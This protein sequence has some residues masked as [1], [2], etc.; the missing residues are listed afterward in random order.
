MGSEGS[1]MEI[2]IVKIG[3]PM[4]PDEAVDGMKF[5][6]PI[7]GR[8]WLREGKLAPQLPPH[9]VDMIVAPPKCPCY[10]VRYAD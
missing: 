10:R 4:S 3:S 2:E 9:S 6:C 5:T 8:A 1:I 7:C